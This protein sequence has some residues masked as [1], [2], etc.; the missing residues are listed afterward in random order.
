[1]QPSDRQ[2]P[3]EVYEQHPEDT[4]ES[5]SQP[6]YEFPGSEPSLYIAPPPA[7]FA[8]PPAPPTPVKKSRA[9]IWIVVAFFSLAL[10]ATCGGCVWAFYAVLGPATQQLSG[11]TRVVNDYYSNIKAQNYAAAYLDLSL[12][13]QNTLTQ[14]QFVQQAQARDAQYGRVTSYLMAGLSTSPST[15]G[16]DPFR[17]TITATVDVTRCKGESSTSRSCTNYNTVLTLQQVAGRWKI[18]DFYKI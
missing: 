10:L 5:A 11:A 14:D 9:W 16:T 4:L 3:G 18:V 17:L 8:P 2:S 7:S 6:L 15:T 12:N 1:M 13:G